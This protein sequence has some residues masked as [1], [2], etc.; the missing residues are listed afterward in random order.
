M[1]AKFGVVV[2]EDHGKLPTLYWLHKPHK[3]SYKS[4]FIAKSSSC[5]TTELSIISTSLKTMSLNT[6][7]QFMEANVN[8]YVCL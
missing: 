1:A 2:D 3:L 4:S 5:K 6:A 7:Q 8:I